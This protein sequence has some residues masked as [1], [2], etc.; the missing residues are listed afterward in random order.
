MQKDNIFDLSG[1]VVLVT[2]GGSGIGRAYCEAVAEFGADVVCADFVAARAE[3]TVSMIHTFG[4]GCV[5]VRADASKEEDIQLMVN[6]SI[7]EFGTVDVVFANAG[8]ADKEPVPIHE[9]SVEDWDAVMALQPRGTF[10]LMKAVFPIVMNKRQGSFI[11]TASIGGLTATC[12][13]GPFLTLTAYQTAKAAVILLTKM[14]SRQYGEHGIR[15]NTICPGYIRTSMPPSE[16]VRAMLEEHTLA[17][18]PLKRIGMPDELK[19]MAVWLASDASSF[20]T[21]QTFVQDGGMIA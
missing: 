20:V 4:H 11:S 6:R 8:I 12:A 10:L 1:K 13:G 9:K 5:A 21:G 2:G 16:E 17:F 18:T 7:K 14:A 15:V 3:E 19:G